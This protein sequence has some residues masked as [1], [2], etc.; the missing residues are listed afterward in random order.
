MEQRTKIIIGVAAVVVLGLAATLSVLRQRDQGIEVRVETVE[1]RDLEEIVTASGNIRARRTVDMSSD[2]S[3]RVQ[4]LLV[5]EGQDVVAGQTL[6]RLEPD[7]YRAALSRAEASLAQARSQEAQQRAN[8][9]QAQRDLGRL[10][11]LRA[12]DSL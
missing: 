9:T 1:R 10:Q 7:Q 2:I 6:L 3:A 11:Q 12:R 8:L 4:D 5:Q